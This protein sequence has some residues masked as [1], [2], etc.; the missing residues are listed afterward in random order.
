MKL[1]STSTPRING[2]CSSLTLLIIPLVSLPSSSVRMMI[3]KFYK[4]CTTEM[5]AVAKLSA[6]WEK[7]GVLVLGLS[8]DNVDSHDGIAIEGT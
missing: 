5:G 4:V 2:F 8:V 7:R 6:E 1:N 3:L